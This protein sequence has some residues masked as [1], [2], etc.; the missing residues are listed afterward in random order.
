M[1][2]SNVNQAITKI[3]QDQR[4]VRGKRMSRGCMVDNMDLESRHQASVRGCVV[5]KTD[6]NSTGW[7]KGEC[8]TW[9]M[10]HEGV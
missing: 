3:N 2:Q 7:D 9:N 6:Q 10:R 8:R 5:D 4:S 1:C